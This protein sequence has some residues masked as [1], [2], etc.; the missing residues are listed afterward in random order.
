MENR[1]YPNSAR[2]TPFPQPTP[3][4]CGVIG[5]GGAQTQVA[6]PRTLEGLVSNTVSYV[7][8]ISELRDM[9]AELRRRLAGS[10]PEEASKQGEDYPPDGMLDALSR[11]QGHAWGASCSLREH[12]LAISRA[13]G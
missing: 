5:G 8:D 13:L 6:S 7:S 10:W 11:F 12:L 9:A 1:V 3:A 4:G 2:S